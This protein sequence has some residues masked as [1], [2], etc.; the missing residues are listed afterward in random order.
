MSSVC[1]VC[2]Q[3][4]RIFRVHCS[5]LVQILNVCSVKPIDYQSQC[6]LSGNSFKIILKIN[7]SE[8]APTLPSAMEKRTVETLVWPVRSFCLEN[9]TLHLNM[10]NVWKCHINGKYSRIL[11]I[12][13]KG[14]TT[15]IFGK[16]CIKGGHK[17]TINFYMTLFFWGGFF[18]SFKSWIF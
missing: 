12:F 10:Y 14:I 18:Q 6:F 16:F 17:K 8:I 1:T 13:F 5:F 15:C 11:S 7:G 3:P 4:S 9:N 2:T